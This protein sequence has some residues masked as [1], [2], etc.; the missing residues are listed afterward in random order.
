M[1]Q[2]KVID[3]TM[4]YKAGF[5]SN[6]TPGKHPEAVAFWN[7]IIKTAGGMAISGD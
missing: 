3:P 1:A 4:L 2:G 5:A 7:N 6:H